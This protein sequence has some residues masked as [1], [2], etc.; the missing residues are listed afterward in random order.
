M[1]ECAFCDSIAKM[2][3]EHLWSEWMGRLFPKGGIT[4]RQITHDGTISREWASSKINIKLP[5]VCE[6]CNTGWMSRLENEH[7]KPAMRELILGGRVGKFG[8][9]RARGLS[10]FAFKTAIIGNRSLPQSEWFFDRSV[11]HS[12]RKSL[13]IPPN[14]S[15]YLVGV[16]DL[17]HGAFLSRN[18]TYPGLALNVCTFSIGHLAFQVVSGKAIGPGRFQ[19]VPTSP[20][21]A[22]PF[23]PS[24]GHI[25]WPRKKVLDAKAFNDFASRW[26]AIRRL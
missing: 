17:F 23:Y 25:S 15:M 14:V 7:A 26:N 16:A 12:F 4:V 10:L 11:R 22:E 9:K 13:A 8:R 24:F 21:L 6:P 20:G 3:A 1:Q 2:S 5:V 19:S 18:V